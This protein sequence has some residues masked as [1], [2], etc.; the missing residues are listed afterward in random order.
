MV[1]VGNLLRGSASP[2][3]EMG[4]VVAI[5]GTNYIGGGIF[6]GRMR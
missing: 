4:G 2:V 1:M 3:G 6:A 5:N